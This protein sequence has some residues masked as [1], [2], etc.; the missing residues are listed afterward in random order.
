LIGIDTDVLGIQ[1]IFRQDKRHIATSRFMEQTGPLERGV[2]IFS[3]LELCGLVATASQPAAATRIFDWYLTSSSIRLLY[4]PVELESPYHFWGQQN[5]ELLARIER[6]LRLGDAAI[7]WTV[8]AAA[9]E[10]LITW[11]TKHYQGRTQVTVMTPQTWLEE[12]SNVE[13]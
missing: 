1:H 11:N 8:E 9:C 2:P 4:P 7:L 5:A 3:L 13:L 12:R 6:G 10:V